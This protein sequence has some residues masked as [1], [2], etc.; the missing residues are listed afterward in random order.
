M[1]LN[2]SVYLSKVTQYKYEFFIES[3]DVNV[4]SILEF[5][6]TP[7]EQLKTSMQF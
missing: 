5:W 7:K 4:I 2:A 1:V 3:F 6:H